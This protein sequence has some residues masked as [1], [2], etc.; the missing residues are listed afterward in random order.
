MISSSGMPFILIHVRLVRSSTE[1]SAPKD[2]RR[3][4]LLVVGGFLS[5]K[6]SRLPAINFND[7]I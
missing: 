4:W 7:Y 5:G 6:R 1:L 3:T 2:K